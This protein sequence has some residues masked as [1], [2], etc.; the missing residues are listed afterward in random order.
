MFK[1]TNPNPQLDMFKEITM[2]LGRCASKK[3]TDP[4][5]W[6]NQFY[7]LI[8]SKI[9]ETIVSSQKQPYTNTSTPKTQ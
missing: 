3:Y 2:Q 7:K 6:H 8:T 5:A 1:K 4:F 9:D